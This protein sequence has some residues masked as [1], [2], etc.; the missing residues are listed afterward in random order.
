[1][2]STTTRTLSPAVVSSFEKFFNELEYEQDSAAVKSSTRK[3]NHVFRY[4]QMGAA[5]TNTPRKPLLLSSRCSKQNRVR[6]TEIIPVRPNPECAAN[7]IYPV[8]TRSAAAA[9]ALPRNPKMLKRF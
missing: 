5:V 2:S 9:Y 8:K 3:T 6:A 4:N 7:S 1:M